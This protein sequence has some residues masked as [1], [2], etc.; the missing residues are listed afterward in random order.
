M[1]DAVVK[2]CACRGEGMRFLATGELVLC[3]KCKGEGREPSPAFAVPRPDSPRPGELA[4]HEL[5]PW[6]AHYRPRSE[7]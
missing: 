4:P 5:A 7:A 2:C 3:W 6:S 1:R